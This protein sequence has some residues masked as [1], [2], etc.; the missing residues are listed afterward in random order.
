MNDNA[1]KVRSL[2]LSYL[3]KEELDFGKMLGNSVPMN[4]S[5]NIL[6]TVDLLDDIQDAIFRDKFIATFNKSWYTW[7]NVW[8]TKLWQ[9]W[10]YEKLVKEISLPINSFHGTSIKYSLKNKCPYHEVLERDLEQINKLTDCAH[11]NYDLYAGHIEKMPLLYHFLRTKELNIKLLCLELWIKDN[12]SEV[13]IMDFLIKSIE[14]VYK[15][16]RHTIYLEIP[17]SK[18]WSMLPE[19]NIK[20]LAYLSERIATSPVAMKLCIDIWHIITWANNKEIVNDYLGILSV[21]NEIIGMLHISSAGSYKK[22]F[23][24]LYRY[25]H[26][27]DLPSWHVKWL[28]LQLQLNEPLMLY[29]LT[30]IRY[31]LKDTNII[32]VSELRTPRKWIQDYFK[33]LNLDYIDNNIYFKHLLDQSK[34]LWYNYE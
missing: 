32:E 15:W 31:V 23:I 21:Y 3:N 5:D 17:W 27:F 14:H 34:L 7:I 9:D 20:N 13:W 6:S 12:I 2:I 29:L 1:S 19:I 28:D 25:V 4:Y 18:G 11:I 26:W 33:G 10:N 24:T 8:V 22:E 30:Q 16:T